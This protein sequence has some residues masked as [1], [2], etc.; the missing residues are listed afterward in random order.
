MS[1]TSAHN[2]HTHQCVSGMTHTHTHLMRTQL[3]VNPHRLL[4]L[5]P[6]VFFLFFFCLSSAE[7]PWETV[8]CSP[9]THHRS[10]KNLCR[11]NTVNIVWLERGTNRSE[12]TEKA[13]TRFPSN[14]FLLSRSSGTDR[15]CSV[16]FLYGPTFLTW[17][18]CVLKSLTL[19]CL[20]GNFLCS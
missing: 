2:T 11:M 1:T 10:D 5:R 4:C 14:S 6:E 20:M 8:Q 3:A 13:V 17:Q 18:H 19:P 15:W 12:Q 16:N 7:C 9:V